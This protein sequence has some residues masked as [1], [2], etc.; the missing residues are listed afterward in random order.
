M[1]KLHEVEKTKKRWFLRRRTDKP[2]PIPLDNNETAYGG[3][4]SDKNLNNK[5][6]EIDTG[7]NSHDVTPNAHTGI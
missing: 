4:L 2:T 5:R 6:N 3:A 7:V 1:P